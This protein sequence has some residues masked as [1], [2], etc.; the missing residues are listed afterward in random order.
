MTVN[1]LN[2][3]QRYLV[4]E[5]AEKWQDGRIGRREFVH[6]PQQGKGRIAWSLAV[7]H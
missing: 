5:E 2:D 3:L 1:D 7:W 4:E 6:R